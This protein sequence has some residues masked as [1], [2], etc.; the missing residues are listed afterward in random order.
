MDQ[1]VFAKFSN[2]W[3]FNIDILFYRKA[4]SKQLMKFFRTRYLLKNVKSYALVALPYN[5][6]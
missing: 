3:S 1:F 2:L 5:N 4:Y 6:N